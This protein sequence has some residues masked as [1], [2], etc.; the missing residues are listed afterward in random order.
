[1]RIYN[2]KRT[3]EI[4]IRL[5]L[6]NKEKQLKQITKLC[7]VVWCGRR[8]GEFQAGN[9]VLFPYCPD[10]ACTPE[11]SLG[12]QSHSNFR[13]LGKTKNWLFLLVLLK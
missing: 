4:K 12:T 1:M 5:K 2:V 6:T 9:K 3:L 7:G 10:P 13:G 8:G 11:D